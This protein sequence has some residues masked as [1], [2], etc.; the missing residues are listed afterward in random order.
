M[1]KPAIFR[2]VS[3][4]VEKPITRV[5]KYLYRSF[6]MAYLMKKET[7]KKYYRITIPLCKKLPSNLSLF[8]LNSVEH[9]QFVKT[10]FIN[11]F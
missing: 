1:L 10:E 6:I 2:P 8:R 5:E 3:W 4:R 7:N 11:Q 9:S